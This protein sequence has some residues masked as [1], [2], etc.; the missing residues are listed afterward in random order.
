MYEAGATGLTGVAAA[1]FLGAA[2][3]LIPT[4]DAAAQESEAPPTLSA[5]ALLPAEML[6][7]PQHRVDERVQNDGYLN[8]YIVHSNFGQFNATSTAKLRKRVDEVYAL[9]AMEEVEGTD[10][11]GEAAVKASKEAV[12]GVKHLVLHPVDSVKGAVSGVAKIFGRVGEGLFGSARSDAEDGRIRSFIGFSESKRDYAFEF[13]V[14]PYSRNEVL[15]ERL[16]EISWAGFAGDLAPDAALAAVPGGA[17]IALSVTQNS[18]WLNDVLRTT[19]PIDLRPMNRD[20][21]TAM[22]VAEETAVLFIDNTVYT[23]REQT[24]LVLA[25]EQMKDVK[26]RAAFVR[27]AVLTD[28]VDVAYFRQ[29]QAQMYAALHG[30][31]TPI[32]RFVPIGRLAAAQLADGTLVYVA[33][34]DM[35]AW[36]GPMGSYITNVNAYIDQEIKPSGKQLWLAGTASEMARSNLSAQGWKVIENGESQLL[37]DKPY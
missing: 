20:K 19:A 22:G 17:G 18:D 35:L 4:P 13:G 9:A 21:L 7:G 10:V 34:L 1:V 24:L 32:A 28:D 11:F 25:L 3:S 31:V 30:S 36:T 2:L 16:N 5:A 37:G 8:H 29:R 33:P 6:K 26:D 12:A 15:Q 27:F 23:P 14:D